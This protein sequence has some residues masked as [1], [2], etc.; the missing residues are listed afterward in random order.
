MQKS[1]LALFALFYVFSAQAQLP[2]NCNYDNRLLM[3][4]DSWAQ[5]MY[6]DNVH[7]AALDAYG[8]ADKSI[9]SEVYEISLFSS[10]PDPQGTYYAVSGSEARQWRDEST[11]AYMQNVRDRLI[12]NPQIKLVILSL[13]GND[14]LA[15]RSDCGWYKNMNFDPDLPLAG[16]GFTNETEFFDKLESDITWIIDQVLAVRSDVEVLIS[17]YDYPNFNVTT[18]WIGCLGCDLCDFYACPKRLDLSYD[19]DGDGA[20]SASELVSDAELNQ[21]MLDVEL[22]RQAIANANPRVYYDN[23]MGLTQYY[24]GYAGVLGGA[25]PYPGNAPNYTPGGD[26][27]Y[28]SDRDNFRLVNV[29]L[30]FD[31][32]ADPIHLSPETYFYKAKHQMDRVIFEKVRGLEDEPYSLTVWSDGNND[33]YVDILENNVFNNGLRMGDEDTG[34][35]GLDN[36]YRSILSFNTGALPNNAT[37]TGASLYIIRSSEVDN[38]FLHTDRNPVMDIKSGHFGSSV[39]LEVAD[40]TAPANAVDVGCFIGNATSN[41]RAIRIDV[42][43]SALQYVNVFGETQ[44][45]LYF[46]FADW[47]DEYINFYDGAGNAGLI[48]P[49]QAEK[50]NQPVYKYVL[51]KKT[52]NQD[53][54]Y[55]E[56]ILEQSEELTPREGYVFESHVVRSETDEHGIVIESLLTLQVVEHPGLAKY[57]NDYQGA[58][59]GGYAPFLDISYTIALPIEL[60]KFEV[61]KSKNNASLNWV[62]ASEARSKGFEV[63]HS[64]DAR[65]WTEIG[66]VDAKGNSSNTNYYGFLHNK[67]SAGYNYYRLK[68]VDESGEFEYSDI[69][70]IYIEKEGSTIGVY[71]NPFTN[72]L[73]LQFDK[74]GGVNAQVQVVNMLGRIV[75]ESNV[76]SRSADIPTQDLPAGTYFVRVEMANE[77]SVV[78]VVKE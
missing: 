45:R 2:Q 64:K 23:S 40:G 62:T 60:A 12:A 17:S 51:K 15:G 43:A 42:D 11:Y 6:D 72:E 54:T 69:K 5:Y 19:L 46:D 32:P 8:H 20:I 77:I 61:R 7:N 56:E 47:S 55:K 41:K 58:P 18:S 53:G 67:P 29:P 37:I 75:Y 28:P 21:M 76:S 10:D 31:A 9:L 13:G 50:D 57:M 38:P 30:W 3:M 22:R 74:R 78:K 33:G 71:P 63:E 73:K 1:L 35:F 39:S 68:M 36:D 24:Y 16:C 26:P 14:V 25:S 66:W 52:P 59:A 27:N 49:S 70:N 48:P 34:W 4:G 65:N 44:F